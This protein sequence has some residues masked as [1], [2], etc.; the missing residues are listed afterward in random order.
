ML[1]HYLVN[2]QCI[3]TFKLEDS[4]PMGF[5]A[6]SIKS[7]GSSLTTSKPRKIDHSAT[8]EWVERYHT[9]DK[10]YTTEQPPNNPYNKAKSMFASIS[11]MH[12]H[13]L[14][15]KK[16]TSSKAGKANHYPRQHQPHHP[17]ADA[18][19]A[20][21][22]SNHLAHRRS[23]QTNKNQSL[24]STTAGTSVAITQTTVLRTS[25]RPMTGIVSKPNSWI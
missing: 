17:Y 22:L 8:L 21:K 19:M 20:C 11:A 5:P 7:S 14:E 6:A 23:S 3:L 18:E 2:L 10:A 12:N 25:S 1:I 15:A 4:T 24:P 13:R 16:S 9:A